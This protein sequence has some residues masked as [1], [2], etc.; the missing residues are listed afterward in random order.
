MAYIKFE[1]EKLI[2]LE[3]SLQRELL[4]TNRTGAYASTTIIGCNTRKYHGL[5]V[6][7]MEDIDDENHVLLSALDV[8]V[9]QHGAM[10][11]FGVRKYPGGNYEPKGHKYIVNFEID[12][13]PVL[14]YR[15][16][17]VVL[18]MERIL[19]EDDIIL[20][21]YTLRDAHSKTLIRFK[22]F[23][24]FRNVHK[25]SKA[26]I[27]VNNK[28]AEIENGIKVRMYDGY[29][30]LNMQFNKKVEYIHVPDWY[31]NV[32]YQEEQ[33]RGYEYQ[34]DL[35]VPGYFETEI[36]KGESII[37]TAGLKEINPKTITRK[38]SSEVEKR[39]PRNS[40]IDCLKNAAQQFIIKRN[41]K[42]EI[43]AGYPWFGRWGRDTFI[44]LPGLT[45][46]NGDLKTCED[47]IDTMTNELKD[48]LFPN[49]GTG[50]TTVMNSV[51][52][53]L[54]FFWTLQEY[55]KF[56]KD[57]KR[58]WEN[59]GS[60]I[61]HILDNYR[62]GTHYNIKMHDN[63]LI[64]AG[65]PGKALTWMDAIV[66]GKPVT[67]RHG[68][69]VEINALWYNA[70]CFALD[71]AE[72]NNDKD[73][74]KNWEYIPDMIQLSFNEYFWDEDKKYLAD[75]VTYDY[76]DFTIRPNQLFACSL[77]YTP[78]SELKRERILETVRKFL[79]TPK[80]IRSLTPHHPDY[81]GVCVG[82]QEQRDLAYHQGTV[83]PWLLGH[84]AE[85]YLK[86]H[87][88]SALSFLE[89]ILYNFE[90]DIINHGIGTISEIYDGDPP[91][92]PRGAI[93]QAW[94]VAELIRIHYMLQEL[95]NK[96]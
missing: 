15:V 19:S 61:K 13:T 94:S 96:N 31:Y 26:N 63:G 83:W 41:K 90:E 28:Y 75:F 70:V 57:K 20:I 86:I 33:N 47:A 8:S 44:A 84:F 74:I 35:Y 34:E 95:K 37:F 53:P 10:F 7:P 1:K 81:K 3:Y 67:P 55:L 59:Y 22:P 79:L 65:A 23:L 48:G 89:E 6:C 73:F 30:A 93:S 38:F 2:N 68:F 27:F 25:L 80:G 58:V 56:S 39:I 18:D 72:N 82:N 12:R 71:L 36:K 88:K 46:Y 21:K 50:E 60:K 69:P 5:L 76:K 52:A 42:T 16:G 62:R 40:F 32:E 11:N 43:I 51:D 29:K 91:H 64:W 14:T 85:A 78:I 24:A 4:R 9:I 87:G 17:G 49:I 45:L 54:W 66:G 77:P 92:S